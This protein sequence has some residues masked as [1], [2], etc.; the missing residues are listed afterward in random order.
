MLASINKKLDM[1]V[2]MHEEFS[3]MRKSLE[4]A[5]CQ[6][7]SLQNSNRDLQTS[8]ATL[9]QQMQNVTAENKH[10]KE[11]ILDIQARSMRDNLIFSGIPEAETD[12]PELSIQ[13]F[14]Q[15]QLKLSPDVI[16]KI[17]FHRVHRLGKLQERKPRPIIAKFEHYQHKELLKSK[18]KLLKDTSFGMNDQYPREINERRKTLYPILKEQRRNNIRAVLAVD[19]LY[20]NGQL[21]RSPDIT[22]WLF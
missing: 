17:T 19:K 12:N 10:M 15:N 20:I 9:T 1:L 16:N 2:S 18:G 13:H 11:T 22:P 5:H 7:E 21:F 14:M 8:V 3:D 4:F 6:I